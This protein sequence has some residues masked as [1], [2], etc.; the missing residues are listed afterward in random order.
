M[1]RRRMLSHGF[2]RKRGGDEARMSEPRVLLTVLRSELEEIK[3]NRLESKWL[4]PKWLG[5]A[6]TN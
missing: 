5:M 2:E 3:P 1:K 4:E 6:M